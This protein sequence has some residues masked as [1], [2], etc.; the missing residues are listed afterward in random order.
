MNATAEAA[1]AVN[2]GRPVRTSPLPSVM[3]AM[4]RTLGDEEIAAVTRVIRSGM[5]SATWGTEVAA[6]EREFAE[7]IGSSHAVACSSGTA[8]LHLAVAAVNPEP[9]DEIIT[10][11]ISDMGTVAPILAQNAV[12]VFADVDPLT[13]TLDPDSV[14]GLIGPRTKAIIA[15]HLFGKPAAIQA[16]RAIAERAGILLI[17]DCAQAYA[18]PVDGRFCGTHGHIGCFSL[19][20]TKHITA[21]DGGL[22]ITDDPILAR[23]MR[24]FADKG[25]PRDSGER[26]YLFLGLNYRMTELTGGVARAQLVKLPGVVER[27]RSAALRASRALEGLAGVTTPPDEGNH[28]YWLYPLLIDPDV[29]GDTH[30]WSKALAA[31]GV[32]SSPGYLSAPLYAAPVLRDQV[33]YGESGYPLAG[34]RDYD[35][36]LCP[37]AEDLIARRLL[38]LLWNE[39]FTDSDVDDITAAVRKVHA[40]MVR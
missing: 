40:A 20:Q 14:A 10:T 27:R 35:E 6:L 12:P 30:A 22:V 18:A 32:P 9:G 13:G 24:L 28:T 1:L 23:R 36:G 34:V 3:D 25:W 38:T 4:G 5:L 8:A 33:T 39:A 37:V 31:E 26:T 15:V 21:G 16:L 7:F 2:G 19:Q 17:E 29:A 11:P